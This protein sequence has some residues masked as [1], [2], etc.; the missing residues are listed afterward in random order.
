MKKI[1]VLILATFIMGVCRLYADNDKLITKERLPLI[2]QQF[3]D[4]HFATQKVSYVKLERDFL[5]KNY[6]I[7]FTDGT[8]VEF[9]RNGEWKDVDCRFNEVP[10]SIVPQEIKN[11][12]SNN[13][14]NEKILQIERERKCYDV[15]LSNRLELTFDKHYNL[16]NIDD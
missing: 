8:K 3:V 4:K 12:I 11:Y 14:P 9:F 5:E 10:A 6:K 7:V 13:Y 2:S 16:I 15:H 1:L